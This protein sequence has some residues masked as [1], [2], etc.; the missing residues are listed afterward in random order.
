MQQH[1]PPYYMPPGPS[2]GHPYALNHPHAQNTN[3]QM[4]P[5]FSHPNL[6]QAVQQQQAMQQRNKNAAFMRENQGQ[7][8]MRAMMQNQMLAPSM[9]NIAHSSGYAANIQASQSMQNVNGKFELS[10]FLNFQPF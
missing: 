6:A 3:P 8:S 4:T 1:R 9:P 7:Q 10:A 5:T 2:A